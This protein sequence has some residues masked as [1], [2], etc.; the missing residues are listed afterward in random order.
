M[1][2]K[3]RLL[4]TIIILSVIL[5]DQ[6]SKW[7]IV[8]HVPLYSHPVFSWGGDFF[9][10]IHVRNTG[11]LFSFGHQWPFWINMILLKIIPTI[12]LFYLMF[13]LIAPRPMIV[14]IPQKFQLNLKPLSAVA[15]AFA[16]GGGLGNM[17]D[18]FFRPAGVVDFLDVKFYGIFG[19]ERWPTF[20]VA[21][22]AVVFFMILFFL[23]EILQKK[24]PKA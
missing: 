12:L 1:K 14:K 21:D 11:A 20:N 8:K 9:Q 22:M 7:L 24:E 16:V 2:S 10:I 13:L 4:H 5:L 3:Q 17:I 18:R 23:S 15:F 19:W 6:W